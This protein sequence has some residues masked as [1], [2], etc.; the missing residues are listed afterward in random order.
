MGG[1]GGGG[2][3]GRHGCLQVE[4]F[5]SCMFDN[6]FIWICII[7]NLLLS[8]LLELLSHLLVS[9]SRFIRTFSIFGA[10]CSAFIQWISNVLGD[11]QATVHGES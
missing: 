10:R 3:G 7:R 11:L 6:D 8:L 5:T 9:L 2:V 1:G 4:L